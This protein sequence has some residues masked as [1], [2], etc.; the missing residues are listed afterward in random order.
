M[1]SSGRRPSGKRVRSTSC[2]WR[3][4]RARWGRRS[5][6]WTGWG[7]WR[8]SPTRALCRCAAAASCGAAAAPS[9]YAVLLH[10]GVCAYTHGSSL[11]SAIVVI[12]AENTVAS[13]CRCSDVAATGC[14]STGL[15]HWLSCSAT[16]C[17]GSSHNH[18]AE[19]AS[20]MGGYDA[21]SCRV[22]CFPLV[23]PG[24]VC[25]ELSTTKLAAFRNASL[26]R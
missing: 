7:S 6:F 5:P 16:A 23:S 19:C 26:T 22:C 24:L 12:A 1:Q 8:S 14:R 11:A 25:R 10:C 20:C 21:A 18:D 17:A 4:P 2:C 3:P 15:W 13:A 9:R